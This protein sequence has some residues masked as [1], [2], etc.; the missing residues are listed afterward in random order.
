MKDNNV[1][2]LAIAQWANEGWV[3]DCLRQGGLKPSDVLNL[4]PN[5]P[6]TSIGSTLLHLTAI[7]PHRPSKEV[8]RAAMRFLLEERGADPNIADKYGRTP[9]VD[10]M[11]SPGIWSADPDYGKGGLQLLLS[12]GADANVLFMPHFVGIAGCERWR[13]IHHFTYAAELWGAHAVPP[14]MMKLLS[15][16]WDAAL[17]DSRGRRRQDYQSIVP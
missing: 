11:L 4:N 16:H 9:L 3:K 1:L 6:I 15:Q 13:L 7:C 12:H 2:P 10:F 8:S 17:P 5:H 14:E